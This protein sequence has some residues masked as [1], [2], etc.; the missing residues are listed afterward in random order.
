MYPKEDLLAMSPESL[1]SNT[2]SKTFFS[3][4]RRVKVVFALNFPFKHGERAAC[5]KFLSLSKHGQ[6]GARG[7]EYRFRSY[8]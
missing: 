8:L 7:E 5:D 4:H 2:I 1:K 3:A 6:G